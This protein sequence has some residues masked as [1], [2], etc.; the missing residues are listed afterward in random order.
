MSERHF[1]CSLDSN[2]GYTDHGIVNVIVNLLHL[3][4]FL[5]LIVGLRN[6]CDMMFAPASWVKTKLLP[7]EAKLEPSN[8]MKLNLNHPR[9]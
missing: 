8:L 4:R 7:H 6:T 1:Q 5:L 3:G 9:L 2:L